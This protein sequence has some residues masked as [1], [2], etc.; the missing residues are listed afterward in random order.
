MWLCYNQIARQLIFNLILKTVLFLY[1]KVQ[2]LYI[3]YFKTYYIYANLIIYMK[4]WCKQK[5]CVENC[6][7]THWL[8]TADM[9]LCYIERKDERLNQ[10]ILNLRNVIV[11][12]IF[13]AFS[14]CHAPSIFK[15]A[16]QLSHKF[17]HPLF[18]IPSFRRTIRMDEIHCQALYRWKLYE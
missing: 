16:L 17:L 4:L 15:L 6:K 14:N 12:C 8:V 5:R 11:T 10:V 1:Q 13:K 3:S 7:T 9:S 2:I 18:I